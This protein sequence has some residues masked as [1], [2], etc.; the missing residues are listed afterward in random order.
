MRQAG[1]ACL[2]SGHAMKLSS[3]PQIYRHLGRWYE[4]LEV[5]SKYGLAAWI[6]RLGPDFAKD[7]LKT[8]GG[9][10][11]A[12][13]A[14][15][16]R[17]RL[18]AAELGPTFIKLG[19]ILST[20]PDLVGVK[21][22]DELQQLQAN[23]P[24]DPPAVVRKLVEAEL[25][26]P[27]EELFANFEP[28]AMASASIGQAHRARLPSGESVVVKVLHADIEKKVAVDMDILAGLAQAAEMIPEF[29]NYRP[30]AI[31]AE[32]QRVMRR[33]LD[34]GREERNLQQ[35]AHDFRG[36]PTVYFPRTYPALSTRRVL[37][38][39]MLDGIKLSESERLSA[40]GIDCDEVARR[41]AAICLKMIF[42][43]NFYHADP[44]PGNLLVMDGCRIGLLDCGMVGR[45]D[46]QLHEDV[47]ELLV[48]LG[49]L[50]AE[51]MTSLILRLGK[52]PSDLDRSALSF[53]VA[54]F[55]SYYATQSLDRFDLSGALKEMVE[56]I[57]RYHIMLP[58]RIA[59]LLKALITLEGT[60]RLVSPKFNLV[61]MIQPYRQK[62]LWRRFSPRR[63]L[64]KLY[65][66]YSELEHLV[67]ILPRGIADVLE[68][69]Q[70]GRFD[71]HLDH[72]GL[73][74]SVNRLVLGMLAS[75][76]FVGASLL[77]SRGVPPLLN[78]PLL[79]EISAPGAAAAAVS[80]AL[81]LRLWRA[82]SKS[83]HFDRKKRD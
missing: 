61:E 66:L 6:G 28:E 46:E 82:I 11:I 53:D 43:H 41:G 17:L 74:P 81:G 44:H 18:A 47:S 12:R 22:A 65:R 58:A 62:M 16:T 2:P 71:I 77:L 13:H 29:R 31:A 67:D 8:R 35:F 39:E 26:R 42:D 56:Q 69:M 59:M 63:R 64:R 15:E 5:L 37:T 19:Q 60:A 40:A 57:R 75:A 24:A 51:H 7:L 32:Y 14:W 45:I 23:V 10:P 52:T 30:A 4:I 27:I 79:P 33:E 25:G 72:R 78:L 55:V 76:L 1:L 50:D 49:N 83:G 80:I 68:Q 70:G 48:A 54:D 21:L 38:M 34:F 36:D 20:R 9:A 3:I 73:E